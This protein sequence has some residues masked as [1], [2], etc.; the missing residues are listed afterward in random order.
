MSD[1]T[2]MLLFC[3]VVVCLFL[4]IALAPSLVQERTQA[5]LVPPTPTPDAKTACFTHLAQVE[6][7]QADLDM[8]ICTL[9]YVRE[10]TE[11]GE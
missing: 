6:R 10:Y 5:K 8:A 7:R 1:I 9:A 4:L 2:K 3:A 11:K